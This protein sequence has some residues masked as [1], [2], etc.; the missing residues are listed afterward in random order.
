MAT[1]HRHSIEFTRQVVHRP[2]GKL[3]RA[4]IEE[5]TTL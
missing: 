2:I 3:C 5:L 1:Q 4:K